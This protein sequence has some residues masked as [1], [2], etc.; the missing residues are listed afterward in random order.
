MYEYAFVLSNRLEV[1]TNGMM[2]F[3]RDKRKKAKA[4]GLEFGEAVFWKRKPSGG[5]LGQLSCFWEDGVCL[6]VKSTTG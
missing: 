3:E 5:N 4:Q 2:A 1:G 6:G